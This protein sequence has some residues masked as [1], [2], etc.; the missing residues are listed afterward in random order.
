MADSFQASKVSANEQSSAIKFNNFVQA[1][2][3]AINSLDNSNV[4]AAAAI[5]VSKLAAGAN[6]TILTTVAGVPTWA[7][8]SSSAV[9]P[10]A[11]TEYGAA[12]A[13]AGWLLCDGTAVS[14]TTYSALFAIISTNYGAGDASTTFN[15]P[16]LRGRVP[17]GKGTHASVDVLNDNDGIS[18]SNRRPQHRHT[19]HVHLTDTHGSAA[20]P[21]FMN[22]G[23]TVVANV[24]TGSADGGSGVAG[25][26][27]DA[28]AYIVVNYIIKT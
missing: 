26:S 6:D 15:L 23:T 25:D 2:E 3:D 16:D 1:V 22:G 18:V 4:G 21:G 27:L 11:M 9:P 19:P 17:V 7:A 8:P 28:P 14:R 13:P 24:N 5:L 12:S 20:N 10:G